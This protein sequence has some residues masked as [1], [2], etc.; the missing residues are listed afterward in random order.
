MWQDA[1]IV[2]VVEETERARTFRLRTR[3]PLSHR[4]GQHLIV[5]LTAPDGYTAMR[6]YS[7]AS[8][9][10]GTADVD[11]TV[12][13]LDGGEV[14]TFLHDVAERGDE[15]EIRGPVGRW[16]VWDGR[17]PALLVAGGSGIVPV[18]SMLRHARNLGRT[19][20]LAVVASF[21]TPDDVY[22]S[23]E[24]F[25]PETTVVYTRRAPVDGRPVG[26]ITL[27]DLGLV[28]GRVDADLLGYVCGSTAFTNAATDL[29]IAGGMAATA[30]RVERFGPTG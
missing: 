9:P 27:D 15:L 29:M 22:Y 20:L 1:E 17:T 12:E 4:A 3:S 2:D 6:S 26:R 28:P 18:M 5:R 10:G 19:D 14:S 30:I 25:G 11:I 8:A 24:L 16:F 7:I 13:R 23:P 21:R